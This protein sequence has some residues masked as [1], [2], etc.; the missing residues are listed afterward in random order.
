MCRLFVRACHAG[1]GLLALAG[2]GCGLYVSER[3]A[4]A[5]DGGGSGG[6]NDAGK[7]GSSGG[8]GNTDGSPPENDAGCHPEDEACG[9]KFKRSVTFDARRLDG[10]TLVDFPVIVMLDRDRINYSVTQADGADLRFV[11]EDGTVLSHEI[12][13]WQRD[14]VSAVWVRLP[15]VEPNSLKTITYFYGSSV[16]KPA[17]DGTKVF[18]ADYEAVYHFA[19]SLAEERV[20][21]D[22][23]ARHDGQ[24][25]SAI[26]TNSDIAGRIGRGLVLSGGGRVDLPGLATANISAFTLELWV[27]DTAPRPNARLICR[28]SAAN[29]Q[30]PV[31]CLGLDDGR[32][33][34]SLTTTGPGGRFDSVS[35][36]QN[37]SNGDW[38]SVAV[39]WD[40]RTQRLR[41]F[42][43]GFALTPDGTSFGGTLVAESVLPWV[44]G[45]GGSGA[46]TGFAGAI[47][48]VRI[49]LVARSPQWLLATGW[50]DTLTTYGREQPL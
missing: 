8:N 47:D 27:R 16:A 50:S 43:D 34:M 36:G 15:R 33:Q 30:Q 9:Y 1:L 42:V 37:L 32:F 26:S 14:G 38:R 35:D 40:A 28:D 12:E 29:P 10:E 46:V 45:G 21:H 48:E 23:F 49:S 2:S 4:P 39:V 25:S 31:A 6:A 19:D 3:E 11:D 18:S 5:A 13:T 7:N 44:L 24:P 20:I 41:G 17:S 22:V